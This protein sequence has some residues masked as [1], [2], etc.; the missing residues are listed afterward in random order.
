MF[1]YFAPLVAIS[2]LAFAY[3]LATPPKPSDGTGPVGSDVLGLYFIG[4]CIILGGGLQLVLGLPLN[5]LISRVTRFSSRLLISIMS[6]LI[7]VLLFVPVM[8]ESSSEPFEHVLGLA[9]VLV[10]FGLG[11]WFVSSALKQDKPKA[12]LNNPLLGRESEIEP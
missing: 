8:S 3:L 9:I 5:I 4:V 10:T 1:P 7:P 12:R 6:V 11:A 2:V